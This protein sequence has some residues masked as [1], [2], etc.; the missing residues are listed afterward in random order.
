MFIEMF[1]FI[2]TPKSIQFLYFYFYF[3]L[4]YVLTI[5]PVAQIMYFQM[6]G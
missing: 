3:Y 2:N 1:H 4:I 6:L 5:L